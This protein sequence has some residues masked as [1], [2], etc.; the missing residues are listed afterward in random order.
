MF[1]MRGDH[2]VIHD[3]I[4]LLLFWQASGL[5]DDCNLSSR[6]QPL[7]PAPLLSWD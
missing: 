1:K 7:T 3:T 4:E 5:M 6:H 2:L